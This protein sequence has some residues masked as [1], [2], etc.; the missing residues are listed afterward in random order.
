MIIAEVLGYK[1][2]NLRVSVNKVH[3]NYSTYKV[4]INSLY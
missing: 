1:T 4:S 2:F 3:T